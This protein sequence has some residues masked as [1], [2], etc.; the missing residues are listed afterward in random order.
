MIEFL[1][2][3]ALLLLVLFNALKSKIQRISVA[4]VTILIVAFCQFQT[5]HYR[6]EIIHWSEMTKEKYWD[7]FLEVRK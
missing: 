2:V 7:V 5:L 6:Y 4:V 1:P 3:F